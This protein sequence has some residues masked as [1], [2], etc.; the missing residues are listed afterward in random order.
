MFEASRLAFDPLIPWVF[1][2]VLIKFPADSV[3]L[4]VIGQVPVPFVAIVVTLVAGYLLARLLGAHAGWLGRRWA[5]RLA[6]R[7][8]ANVRSEVEAVVFAPIDTLEAA[9]R[10]LWT[11]ARGAA[12]DCRPG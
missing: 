1:L 4:P 7:V 3:V 8:R 10:L 11:V 2:W 6:D 12:Q 5:A 9:R